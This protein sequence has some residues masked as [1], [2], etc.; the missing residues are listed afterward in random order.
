MDKH[1]LNAM[2]NALTRVGNFKDAYEVWQ[3]LSEA[4]NYD[5]A[6]NNASV[7]IVRSA[8]GALTRLFRLDS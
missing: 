2:M 7:N 3:M 8:C 5:Q 4:E 6:A 1:L